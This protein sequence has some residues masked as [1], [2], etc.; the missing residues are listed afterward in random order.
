MMM[1]ATVFLELGRTKTSTS[2]TITMS[3]AIRKIHA[4]MAIFEPLSIVRGTTQH[5]R[6][7]NEQEKKIQM[8]SMRTKLP[9]TTPDP[10]M[11]RHAKSKNN[12]WLCRFARLEIRKIMLCRSSLFTLTFVLLMNLFCVQFYLL[13][14]WSSVLSVTLRNAR[15]GKIA[16]RGLFLPLCSAFRT[17]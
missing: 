15:C 6:G 11:E 14:R 16:L 1:G 5:E 7:R 13:H 9:I 12:W 3:P 10:S 4:T 8:P 17:G 2:P